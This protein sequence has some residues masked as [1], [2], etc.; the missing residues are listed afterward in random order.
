MEK[1]FSRAP[2]ELIRWALRKAGVEKWLVEIV[3]ALYE[4]AETTVRIADGITDWSKVLIG[5]HQGSVLSPLLFITVMEVI[6]R[7][8]SGGLPCELPYAD[9]LILIPQTEDEIRQK[10]TWKPTLGANSTSA[11]QK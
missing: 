1:A 8:I 5:L 7:E 9:D 2:R 4:G 10:L 11:K 6:C 3:M